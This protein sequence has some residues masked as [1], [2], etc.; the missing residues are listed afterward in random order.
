VINTSDWPKLHP[1]AIGLWIVFYSVI[2][3]NNTLF[4]LFLLANLPGHELGH[5]VFGFDGQ[6]ISVMGGTLLQLFFPLVAIV[7]FWKRHQFSGLAFGIFWLGIN[8]IGIGEY[9]ADARAMNLPLV[10]VGQ[11]GGDVIHDWFYMLNQM[12][13][14]EYDTIL[15]GIVKTSGWICMIGVVVGLLVL[16]I[17]NYRKE[18]S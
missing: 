2:T 12:G 14:L 16:G 13:L 18:I 6:F 7:T 17:L 3:L 1:I 9:M 11:S 15:G 4:G 10:S 8:F 5:L